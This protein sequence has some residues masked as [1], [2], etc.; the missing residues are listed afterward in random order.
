MKI[1][2]AFKILATY[3]FLFFSLTLINAQEPFFVEEYDVTVNANIDTDLYTQLFLN[4]ATV[5]I[6]QPSTVN[7]TSLDWSLTPRPSREIVI[8]I[9]GP[10]TGITIVQPPITNAFGQTSGSVSSSVPGTYNVCAKDITEGYDILILDC[11][12]LYVTPVPTPVMVAEPQYTK[13]TKNIVMW[14]MSG[15]G[16]YTYYSQSSTDISFSPLFANS[17]WIPNLLYEF[18]GL[19]DA[20]MY[21]YR[22]KARNTYGGESGWSNTVF[23][24]QDAS[25]PQ[26]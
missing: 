5:E 16:I 26:I 1:I 13:G 25:G 11:E 6:K 18:T 2:T 14:T 9:S 17:S 24:L 12:T 10:S 21:F 15:S 23:S 22:V 3:L 19:Q 8:Y 4:P 20:Q 7:I